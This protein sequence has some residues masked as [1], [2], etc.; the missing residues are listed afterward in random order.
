MQLELDISTL[1]LWYIRTA[2][3][4]KRNNKNTNIELSKTLQKK[5]YA[6]EMFYILCSYCCLYLYVQS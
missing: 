4:S 5:N 6:V 1:Y 3:I 2:H